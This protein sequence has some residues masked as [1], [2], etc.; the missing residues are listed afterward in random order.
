MG[1]ELSE[2]YAVTEGRAEDKIFMTILYGLIL[3]IG[4]MCSRQFHSGNNNSE[5]SIK[6]LYNPLQNFAISGNLNLSVLKQALQE[7][8]GPPL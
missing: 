6:H 3:R 2:L 5:A 4:V 7:K 8:R 1:K